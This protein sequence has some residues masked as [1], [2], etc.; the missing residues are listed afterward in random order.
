V[1][2]ARGDETLFDRAEPAEDFWATPSI[3]HP[4]LGHRIDSPKALAD[5][6]MTIEQDPDQDVIVGTRGGQFAEVAFV[7]GVPRDYLIGPDVDSRETLAAVRRMTRELGAGGRLFLISS[8]LNPGRE[9]IRLARPGLFTDVVNVLGEKSWAS[10][11]AMYPDTMPI[12]QATKRK[13][14]AKGSARVAEAPQFS[15]A[16]QSPLRLYSALARAAEQ[17]PVR[18]PAAQWKGL[19]RKQAKPEEI[20]WSGV[21]DW[22]D[23]Q[24]GNVPR[25][26]VSEFLA[27]N[28]VQ[29]GEVVLGQPS[30]RV[31]N[32]DLGEG[33]SF[34]NEA[35]ARAY[36]EANDVPSVEVYPEPESAAGKYER[37]QLPGGTNYRE[38][39][40]TLPSESTG[41]VYESLHW[42]GTPNVLAHVRMNDRVDAD[43]NKVLFI[44]EL[45]SDWGQTGRKRGF[46]GEVPAA[47]FVQ[48]TDSWLNLALKRVATMAVEGG[49]D[50]V[51]FISGEPSADRYSLSKQIDYIEYEQTSPGKYYLRAT[52]Y[53]GGRPVTEYQQ[54]PEQLEALVGKEIAQKI[55][56]GVGEKGEDGNTFLRTQDLKVGG[57]GMKIFYDSIVPKTISKLLPKIGGGKLEQVA[58]PTR[59]WA[60]PVS[61]NAV[62]AGLGIPEAEWNTFWRELDNAERARLV[63]DYRENLKQA[64]TYPGFAVTPQMAD[65]VMDS[66]LPMFSRRQNIF[67]QPMPAGGWSITDGRFD[68]ARYF[69]QDKLVDTKRV[70]EGITKVAGQ[71]ADKFDA[72]L[73]E[74]LYHGRV[75]KRTS[76]FAEKELKPLIEAMDRNKVTMAEFDEYLHNRHAE[77]RNAQI[78]KINPILPDAGSGIPTAD[79]RA[80]LAA[81]PQARRAMLEG[82][83]RK[84]DKITAGTRAALVAGG[85]ENQST[86]DAWE[87]T[88][89]KYVPLMREDLD[90]DPVSGSGMGAGFSVRGASSK[91][92]TGS[93]TREV[94]DILANVAM[95]RERAI[96]RA[97]KNRVSQALYGL[98]IQNPLADFW[99]PIN[100]DGI[101]NPQ[102]LAQELQQLGLNPLDAQNIAQ[103]PK[104]QYTDPRTGL[105]RERLNP[106]LR[107]AGNVIFTRVNGKDRFLILNDQNERAQRMAAAIKNLDADQLG[108]AMGLVAQGTRWFASVN[109]QYNPIFGVINFVRDVQGGL[110]NLSS[111][112]LAG[113]QGEV[114][115][116]TLPALRGIYSALRT[117]GAT[118]Q[119]AQLWEEF[120]EVGGQTGY[121]AQFSQSEERATALEKELKALTDGTA[122]KA[123]KAVF[124]WLSD[125]NTAMENAVRLSAYKAGLDK[126]MSKERAASLAKNLTVNFNKKGQI[127]TQMG[128]LYAFFNAS[129]QGTERLVQTLAG[130]AGRKI[131][132]GGLLLGSAQALMLAMAGFDEDEPPGFTRERNLI[133]PT[134]G[135]KYITI[136]MPLGFNV[137]PNT[138]R[139][140]TEWA[141]SGFDRTPERAVQMATAFFEMFNPIG[142]AGLSIQTIAPTIVDPLVALGENR[143]WTGAPIARKDFNSLDPTPGYT[144]AKDTA[145][146]FSKELSYYL[147]LASGG[148]EFAPGAFSPTPDQLDYLVG[149]I[150]GGLA[151]EGM[152]VEQTAAALV[153]GQELPPYKI[154]LVGR[155]YGDTAGS[156]ATSSRFYNNLQRMNIHSNEIAGRR[157]AGRPIGEYMAKNPEARLAS[158]AQRTYRDVQKLRKRKRE[159]LDKGASKESIR[160]I[161][162][163]ITRRMERFNER[164]DRKQ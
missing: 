86:I 122:K 118:G 58:L 136:P 28:G 24:E 66:G 98:A 119:W 130:P 56:D 162:Q 89:G 150:F 100:P 85:L 39:L 97:E 141:L 152:K 53:R 41:A 115:A 128:A 102:A 101:K 31:Y 92:A 11:G 111:T 63:A 77:E 23:L 139:I 147:N 42:P 52:D 116:S 131:M 68:E 6:A 142:N 110:L 161:E 33:F 51:A 8:Q 83:A 138:G 75:A 127:A 44:E 14:D 105:V 71:I 16:Q 153:T 2:N 60:G 96:V 55:V 146:W 88:Y 79:A 163:Q 145:S 59:D 158:E 120:Q 121:R 35:E 154:P 37:H 90:F 1:I 62:M 106:A 46:G 103:E 10:A 34:P 99:L 49:Y 84:V 27:Q 17:G 126:G 114:T 26:A 7:L 54:T 134:G 73:Q 113:Q 50:K 108:R 64:Q 87:S 140:L 157:E 21:E 149:Q 124:Q 3:P 38:V 76:D 135:G 159:M 93:A 132:A 72:Y 25:E 12:E 155:F 65:Q 109:T 148:T 95:Q 123:G 156:S 30:W 67:G 144:R 78:A 143:D 9:Y 107:G 5:V 82:L 74:T 57:E 70:I 133:I 32:P 164:L 104:Q 4:A 61:G 36:A 125:Y 18:A 80:Y 19:L 137:I 117:G 112:E 151:R 81:L 48:T 94:V 45:Q 129:V 29:V 20:T 13:T 160:V 15:R 43:G 40:L 69:L 91:R 22:L 47:P